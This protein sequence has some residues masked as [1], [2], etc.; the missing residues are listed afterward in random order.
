MSDLR[1]KWWLPWEGIPPTN[2][3]HPR[4]QGSTVREN[5]DTVRAEIDELEVS[6]V[7]VQE[8]CA[9]FI[10]ADGPTGAD[11][12]LAVRPGQYDTNVGRVVWVAREL[13]GDVETSIRGRYTLIADDVDNARDGDHVPMVN[14]RSLAEVHVIDVDHFRC[15][16]AL[17]R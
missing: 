10:E 12:F 14:G 1:G 15:F 4:L 6:E 13:H 17:I 9:G 11:E 16:D 2:V 3:D 5:V 7:G 8:H